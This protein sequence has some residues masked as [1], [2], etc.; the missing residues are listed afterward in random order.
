MLHLRVV[1]G[2]WIAVEEVRRP[3]LRSHPVILGGLPHQRGVVREASF[4]AQQRGVQPGMPLSQA[5][6]QCPNGIFLMPDLPAYETAWET[7]CD[8]LRTYTPLVEPLQMGQAVLDLSG[9]ERLWGDGLEAARTISSHIRRSTGIVPWLGVASN[10]L[11][12]QLASTAVG[13]EGIAVIERGQEATFL[14][15]LSI[16]LLPGIDPRLALTFQVLGLR[17]IGQLA[18]LPAASVRQRFGAVGE[19]L[20]SYARGIDPRPVLPPPAK[21]SV[22]ARRE[23]EDGSI[24]E[25]VEAL[26][27][28]ADTC[29]VELQ[30][31]RLAGTVLELMLE[32]S[33][34][35]AAMT[36]SDD[37]PSGV[38]QGFSPVESHRG[39][40]PRPVGDN[41]Q[42]SPAD[43]AKALPYTG[44]ENGEPELPS[45]GVGEG[46]RG[47]RLPISYRIHSMLPQPG[48]APQEP[49][50]THAQ[51][52]PVHAEP[53]AVP[54]DSSIRVRTTV[55][56]PIDTAPQLLEAAQRL[57]LQHWPKG[58][59][60]RLHAI[61]LQ[62]SQF[63]G[64]RQLSFP[65]LNRIGQVGG[66]AGPS[67]ERLQALAE[68]EQVLATRYG[69]TSF[70]RVTRLDPANILTE[71]RVHWDAGLPWEAP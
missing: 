24:D 2:F 57:L 3:G 30:E 61:E 71:R 66:L 31:R 16:T 32:P 54:V 34:G 14:A 33:P 37:A 52:V 53:L 46:V 9:C 40:A 19:R 7:V 51:P 44:K 21:P 12:A 5:H 55:R 50:A 60:Y 39:S 28:L 13:A 1:P 11:V 17:T 4:A 45:P 56:T 15:G 67:A 64:P 10:R 6:Q 48:S 43:R 49:V 59:E 25:A 58:Q 42:P 8:I 38:G 70:R 27:L 35:S 23:C 62:I 68:G 22:T 26:H 65:E 41:G 63:P 36:S 18:A 20:H 69:D 29:A 47:T